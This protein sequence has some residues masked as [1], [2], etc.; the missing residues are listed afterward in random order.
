MN[1]LKLNSLLFSLLAMVAV[2][3]FMTSCGKE[4]VTLEGTTAAT[5]VQIDEI[6]K[7]FEADP[8]L[9]ELKDVTHQ[10]Q[11]SIRNDFKESGT[12]IETINNYFKV[13]DEENLEKIF[14]D[15]NLP[16][17]VLRHNE[18]SYTLQQ[19]YPS[20]YQNISVPNNISE[21]LNH[22]LDEQYLESRGCSGWYW[23]CVS[24]AGAPTFVCIVTTLPGIFLPAVCY[25]GYAAAVAL[26]ANTYCW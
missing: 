9:A 5:E 23:V 8:I 13:Q 20:L 14:T 21:G 24:A 15:D 16:D 6:L 26:C 1:K 3:L 25:G 12:S 18:L 17:L 2:T 4:D 11:T 19:K 7:E 22:L 10:M